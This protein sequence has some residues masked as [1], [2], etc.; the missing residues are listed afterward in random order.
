MSAKGLQG[1]TCPRCGGV[2]TIPEGLV[3]V[4]CPF[5]EQ[6]SVVS[7]ERGVRRYQVPLQVTRD[8]ALAA[9]QRF[10]SGNMAIARDLPRKAELSEAILVHLPFWSAW[11]RGVAWG[12]GQQEVG[13]GDS[14]RYEPRERRV[15]SEL[16]WNGVA[17]DVGEFGV[18]RIALEGRPL[19][20]FNSEEL[21][22][23]GMV[24]EPVGSEE[25]AMEQAR[26]AF[27]Q[28]VSEKVK[29]D[30]TAQLF[31]R[32]LERRLGLVYYPVWVLRYLYRG[33]SFQV[34]VDGFD[35]QALY[36][37]APGNVLYRAAMLVG[38]MA[39]GAALAI[40]VPALIIA[41]AGDSDIIG[42][43]LV[44]FAAGVGLMFAGWQKFRYGEHFEFQRHKELKGSG[45]TSGLDLLDVQDIVRE[46][47]KLAR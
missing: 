23:S 38:G 24:F 5:C 33:R 17:C 11:G 19:E 45:L 31:T 42:V 4:V 27:E 36:G 6:R 28:A 35:G 18:R 30:R 1:L 13:S 20:P 43:A 22:R 12:F 32:V 44:S 8:Q 34:I 14:R 15:V 9:Y 7:G 39:V 3:M 16:G 37:K 29:L 21:H 25:E 26:R 41:S 10:L 46:V 2:V 47:G 40:D